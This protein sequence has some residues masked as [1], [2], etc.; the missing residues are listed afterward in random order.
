MIN[1]LRSLHDFVRGLD[2]KTLD[3]LLD[4][5]TFASK[6]RADQRDSPHA[7]YHDTDNTYSLENKNGF[8]DSHF[9]NYRNTG[10]YRSFD[11]FSN[12]DKRNME[13]SSQDIDIDKLL[14]E[15]DKLLRRK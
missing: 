3:M 11:D 14:E 15:L 9:S 2:K 12:T 1:T 10:N 5:D 13:G 8:S 7:A 4:E 6:A